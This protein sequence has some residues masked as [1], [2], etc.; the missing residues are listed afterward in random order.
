MAYSTSQ[1]DA[2]ERAERPDE[3]AGWHG[4]PQVVTTTNRR[5]PR[6]SRGE[7]ADENV[8]RVFQ[9]KAWEWEAELRDCGRLIRQSYILAGAPH[10]ASAP[11]LDGSVTTSGVIG[12]LADSA[13]ARADESTGAKAKNVAESPRLDGATIRVARAK[14]RSP[15]PLTYSALASGAVVLIT[16]LTCLTLAVA[17]RRPDWWNPGLPLSLLGQAALT[18]GIVLQIEDLRPRVRRTSA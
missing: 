1:R 4:P 13:A 9:D 16:G 18:M 14:R 15:T 7:S 12:S 11:H 2:V 10:L 8:C 17:A 6:G 5:T 3:G